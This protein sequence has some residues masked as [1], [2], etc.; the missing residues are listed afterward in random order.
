M[1]TDRPYSNNPRPGYHSGMVE[2]GSD[3]LCSGRRHLT[4]REPSVVIAPDMPFNI[5]LS[6]VFWLS[7]FALFVLAAV[8][9]FLTHKRR[10]R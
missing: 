2:L 7:F 9:L 5:V 3:L 10:Q 4:E 8:V 6:L 1:E